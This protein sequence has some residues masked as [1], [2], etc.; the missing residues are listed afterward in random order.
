MINSQAKRIVVVI[1]AL[2]EAD[3]IHDLI[4]E[5]Q[6]IVPVILVDDG[7]SDDTFKNAQLANAT[8]VRHKVSLGYD[9]ALSSG[10]VKAVEMGFTHAITMDADGQHNPIFLNSFIALIDEGADL[11]IGKRDYF[12][13][14]SELLF[15][16]CGKLFWGVSD[17]LCGM[18]AYRLSLIDKFGPFT[19]R[20]SAGTE[21]AIRLIK[22]GIRPIEHPI[23]IRAR[24]DK[25]RYGGGFKANAK[26]LLI[27]LRAVFQNGIK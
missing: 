18:K 6:K 4:N 8:I 16:K 23:S 7:S 1:P 2:N 22:S 11:V 17:P 20:Q 27:L 9:E 14:T 26:I 13:R 21:F 12:Q 25:S 24:S 15:A 3:T 19:R 5:I 10:L